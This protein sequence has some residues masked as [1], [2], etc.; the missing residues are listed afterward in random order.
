MP[1]IG[2]A[3]CPLPFS[4]RTPDRTRWGSP[5]PGPGTLRGREIPRTSGAGDDAFT[6][7]GTRRLWA[8]RAG[9]SGNVPRRTRNA[10]SRIWQT[11]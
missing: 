9:P 4:V 1:R 11:P 10:R 8:V 2:H 7:N 3:R 6:R 5:P